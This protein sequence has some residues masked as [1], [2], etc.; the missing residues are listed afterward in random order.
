MAIR[1]VR[2]P[3]QNEGESI[4]KI[5]LEPL[6]EY[7][8]VKPGQ[9]IEVVAKFDGETTNCNFTI[10]PDGDCLILYAPGEISGF[11]DCFVMENG[12]RL[13]PDGN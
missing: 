2:L 11:S 13:M 12:V 6:S 3:I 5:I 9:K 7:F 4:V 1:T 8:L 10:A